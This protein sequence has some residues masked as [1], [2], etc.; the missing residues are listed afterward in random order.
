VVTFHLV[1]F[2]F[3]IFSG[4]VGPTLS[5]Q[6]PGLAEVWS[7]RQTALLNR[8]SGPLGPP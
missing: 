4:H 6:M 5:W 2:G 8:P 7:A 3:L 1:C